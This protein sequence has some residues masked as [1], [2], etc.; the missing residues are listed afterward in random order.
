MRYH[1][2]K[3]LTTFFLLFS[4]PL[5]AYTKTTYMV[6]MRDSIQ[7]ATDVYLANSQGKWPTLLVRTPYGKSEN[8]LI[9]FIAVY[10]TGQGYAVVIQDTRGRFASQGGDSLFLDDGWGD[11]QD[12]YDTVEWIAKQSWSNQKVGTL[13]AS[14]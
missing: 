12:G 10:L 2:I 9:E 7:L 13:G 11:R 5:F 1:M 14:A 4:S 6:A 3:C 8:P